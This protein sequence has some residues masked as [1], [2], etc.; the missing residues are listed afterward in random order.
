MRRSCHG[1]CT[2]MGSVTQ[3]SVVLLG[4][5]GSIGTQ[6]VDVITRNPDRFSVDGPVRGRRRRRACWPGRRASSGVSTV[7]VA[8]PRAEAPL[9]D[10]LPRRRGARRPGRVDRAGRPRRRRGAQRGHRLGRAGPDARGPARGQHARAGE[11]GVARRRRP[12]GARRA[13]APGPDRAGRL[14][15]LGDRAGAAR[16]HAPRGPAARSSRRPA[17]RSAAGRTTTSRRST[18]QQAL[19]HPTWSMG[20]VVTINSSTLMNK[21][22]ELIEAHLLF[23]VPGRGHHRG[24]AP[25][26]GGALD[27]RVRRRLHARAGVAAGHA[28]ADRA[29]AVLAGPRAATSRRRAT[30]RRRRRGRSSRWTRRSSRAVRL[31]REAVAASATHP[32]VYNAANEECVE[33]FLAGRIGFLDIVTTVERVLGE[34]DGTS[35]DALDARRGPGRRGRGRAR[36]RRRSWRASDGSVPEDLVQQAAQ[37]GSGDRSGPRCGPPTPSPAG[38]R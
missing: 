6:A 27:G 11:Q 37:R 33:A 34:H 3:R 8:D 21:G 2:K 24:R 15:A 17:A 22:L 36:G 38:S 28:A 25:A 5:T 1:R 12:A 35:P 32:A 20:P 19:A 13:A 9:R 4:S 14:R 26:V 18:P 31:A 23:D 29:R 10:A 7:A 16:R 30:G